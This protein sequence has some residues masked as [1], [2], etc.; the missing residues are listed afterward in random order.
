M[1]YLQVCFKKDDGGAVKQGLKNRK[2]AAEILQ[3]GHFK[4]S[5]DDVEKAFQE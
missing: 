3:Y 5:F 2:S 1:L 4:E